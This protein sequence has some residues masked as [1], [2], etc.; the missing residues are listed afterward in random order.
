MT[1]FKHKEFLDLIIATFV[2]RTN[3][4]VSYIKLKPLFFF[5]Y[6]FLVY[7]PDFFI[8]IMFIVISII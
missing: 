2:W 1:F 8:L 6:C 4:I 5:F 3:A 7:N